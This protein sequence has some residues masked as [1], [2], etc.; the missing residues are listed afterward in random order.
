MSKPIPILICMRN[1]LV[2]DGICHIL[3]SEN[4]NVRA[5]V[6]TIDE[7]LHL[8]IPSRTD[9]II[10][11]CGDG[12]PCH[13]SSAIL[14]FKKRF[15]SSFVVL[16]LEDRQH[17]QRWQVERLGI[18]GVL[19]QSISSEVFI[20]SLKLVAL[21][22]HVFSVP[23]SIDTDE[24]STVLVERSEG[25]SGQIV[26]LP[27]RD[28][29]ISAPSRDD[30]SALKMLGRPAKLARRSELSERE[31]QILSCLVAGNS[32]KVIARLCNITEATVKVHLK[33][34]LR[35]TEVVNRT[36]AAVW[37]LNNVDLNGFAP[38][39]QANGHE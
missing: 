4:Y 36:Q 38:E 3:R 7:A 21:G 34:I 15:P 14:E 20:A 24:R 27:A 1:R 17:E 26:M 31:L 10:I 11:Y 33:A 19:L 5:S 8:K 22:E 29:D 16:L 2:R 18:A 39:M 23:I 25:S 32:N 30:S 13:N 9:L 6:G 37:A 28:D 12:Q 35:K